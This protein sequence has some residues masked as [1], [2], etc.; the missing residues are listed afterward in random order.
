MNPKENQPP[1]QAPEPG[2]PVSAPPNSNGVN[3]LQPAPVENPEA[4]GQGIRDALSIIGVLLAALVLAW[5]LISFVFQSYQVD[6][7]SMQTTLQNDDHLVVWKV[8][9]TLARITGHQ[10]I[11]HRGDVIVF[12]E[13]GL[14]EFGQGSTKQLIKRVIGLPGER[15]VVNNGQ[16]TVYNQ[17]NKKGFDP[18]KTLKYGKVIP[19][20]SGNIDIVLGPKQIFVCGDNR[21]DSLDS[22]VFGPVDTKNI[23]GKLVVRVLPINEVKFF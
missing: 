1:G 20:T 16:V 22:R 7:P 17:E 2:Q 6:G 4:N 23:V 3:V 19:T 14:A 10:Y 15:V 12:N 11:P 21:P 18:D 8:P 5:G 9:R 13:P